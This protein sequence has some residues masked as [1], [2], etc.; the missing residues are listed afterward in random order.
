MVARTRAN[1]KGTIAEG[2]EGN[3]KR[4]RSDFINW[5]PIPSRTN[6]EKTMLP[7]RGYVWNLKMQSI[8][9][10]PPLGI[11]GDLNAESLSLGWATEPGMELCWALRRLKFQ[12]V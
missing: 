6:T 11:I 4:M 7:H 3:L 1:S 12:R 2:A 10:H 8:F 9:P 5:L